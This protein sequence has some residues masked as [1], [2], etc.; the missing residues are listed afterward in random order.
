VIG[1]VEQSTRPFCF[2]VGLADKARV[3]FSEVARQYS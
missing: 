2:G 1:R 3:G